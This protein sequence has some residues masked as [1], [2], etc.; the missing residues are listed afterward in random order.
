MD[1][2]GP[3]FISFSGLPDEDIHEFVSSVESLRKHFKWSNQVTFCYARTMLKGTARKIVQT[4]KPATAAAG[5]SP[6]NS[7]DTNEQQKTKSLGDEAIDPNSWTNLKAALTFEFSDQYQQDRALVQLLSLKQQTGESSSEYAQRFVNAVSA[8]VA[9]HPLDSKLLAVHFANG[10]RSEKVRWELLLRRLDTIDKA[11]AF[12]APE[13]LYKVAKLT[14]LLSPPPTQP[15]SVGNVGELSP[16][17]DSSSSFTASSLAVGTVTPGTVAASSVTMSATSATA[18]NN[19]TAIATRARHP[20]VINKTF[21]Y[22]DSIDDDD[23]LLDNGS[24]SMRGYTANGASFSLDDDFDGNDGSQSAMP[25]ALDPSAGYNA[26]ENGG[27]WTPPSL[28]D[29]RQRRNHRQSMSTYALTH[30]ASISNLSSGRVSS[31]NQQHHT[32]TPAA[33]VVARHARSITP[34]AYASGSVG[35]YMGHPHQYNERQ[36]AYSYVYANTDDGMQQG[37]GAGD[38]GSE[39]DDGSKSAN[40]LNSLADQLESL[41]SMLRVQSDS[42]RR[43]PRLCY[44]CRQKGHIAS[45]CPMPSDVVV[46][47]QQMREKLA[48]PLS[49]LSLV[50]RTPQ[51][52]SNTVSTPP[53]SASP[54]SMTWR[55]ASVAL[56]GSSNSNSNNGGTSGLRGHPGKR[57]G[58]S[59]GRSS[60]RYTQ[61]VGWNSNQQGPGTVS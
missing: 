41:S 20:D 33:A 30:S 10:L 38:G 28:P 45:E 36:D 56:H 5:P 9:A 16:T 32:W 14:P 50:P 18:I 60:R 42:R 25:Y 13:Q 35:A 1:D 19:T 48:I 23:L 8:L 7:S 53:A 52:R 55:S 59:M 6:S 44:R 11:V 31:S 40:E 49:S 57:G 58:G 27:F 37:I 34:N 61:S 43:R 4:A 29:A 47:N 46:P 22:G 2:E 39:T 51:P 15:T 24:G 12:V 3:A 54:S 26:N 21:A 17:S